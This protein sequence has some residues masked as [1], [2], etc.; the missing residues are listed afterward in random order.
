MTPAHH[1]QGALRLIQG[2]VETGKI[3]I[4][5]DEMAMGGQELLQAAQCLVVIV[6]AKEKRHER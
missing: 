4:D 6:P 5:R 3:V 2:E 1:L